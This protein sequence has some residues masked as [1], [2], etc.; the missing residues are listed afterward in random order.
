MTVVVLC[1]FLMHVCELHHLKV[2]S[3]RYSLVWH[4]KLMF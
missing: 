3:S 2:R 4:I 1:V